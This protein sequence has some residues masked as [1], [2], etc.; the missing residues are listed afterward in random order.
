MQRTIC[1]L[2]LMSLLGCTGQLRESLRLGDTDEAPGAPTTPGE[3]VMT[4]TEPVI[5]EVTPAFERAR[6]KLTLLPF[7]V[8]HRRLAALADRPLDD[9]I[10][11]ALDYHRYELG[12]FNYAQG[13][14]PDR[15]WT[16]AKLATWVRALLPIC[17]SQALR[18]KYAGRTALNVQGFIEDAYGRPATQEDVDM[19]Q[20]VLQEE[21]LEGDVAFEA[22][23]IALLSSTEFVAQ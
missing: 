4:P 8:R 2:T 9:A 13:I 21:K 12:D 17:G 19:V 10:F 3:P 23:C 5:P 7:E 1:L 14:R 15:T 20:E 18:Q 22:A 6:D 16:A 11:E